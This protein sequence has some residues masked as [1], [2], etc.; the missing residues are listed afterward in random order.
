MQLDRLF[1][2]FRNPYFIS[3]R[4]KLWEMRVRCEERQAERMRIARDL[5]DTVLQGFLSASMQLHVTV[6]QLPPNSPTKQRLNS[7]LELLGRVL[8]EVRQ[9][10]RGLR[11]K[12]ESDDLEQ[13]LCRIPQE[14]GI[15]GQ[16]D[17]R[18]RVLGFARPL[19]VD[20]RDEVYRIGR[21]ASIN[22][23]RHS[24]ATCIE[25]ELEYGTSRFRLIV[26]DN[27]CG[28]DSQVLRSGT[29]GHWGLSGM[30]ERAERMSA[31]LKIWSRVAAGT[32]VE[33]TVPN[34]IAFASKAA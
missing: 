6:D 18:L 8:D 13:A 23:F 10:I 20:I 15:I 33:L 3:S 24:H 19:F 27:G 25:V 31:R 14:L 2:A 17:F 22:A 26:R 21:E 4:A 1:L 11:S 28:I 5:H 32:E 12:G 34:R 16:I 30:R 7:A 29:D 9:S